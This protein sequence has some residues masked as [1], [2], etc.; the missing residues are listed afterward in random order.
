MVIDEN[1]VRLA[2]GTSFFIRSFQNEGRA[3][4]GPAFEDDTTIAALLKC[5]GGADRCTDDLA[6]DHQFDAPVLLSSI[7]SVIGGHRLSLAEPSGRKRIL[8]H[9]LFSQIIAHCRAALFGELLIV[10]IRAYVV[11]MAFDIEAQPG[12]SG[13]HASHPGQLFTR[14]RPSVRTSRN[15]RGRLTDLLPALLVCR[16]SAESH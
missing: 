8:L 1:Q 9:S 11:G 7:G 15:R 4:T 2:A 3:A 10:S 5:D 16:G 13:D 12:V 14:A 6:R